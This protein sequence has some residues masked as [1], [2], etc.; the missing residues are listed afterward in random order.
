MPSRT[1]HSRAQNEAR[2]AWLSPRLAADGPA[3]ARGDALAT[4]AVLDGLLLLRQMLGPAD[5]NDAARRL[6]TE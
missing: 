1:G 4:I 5:A 2:I 3:A 6:S